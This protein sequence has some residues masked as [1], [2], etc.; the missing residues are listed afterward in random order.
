MVVV[1]GIKSCETAYVTKDAMDTL[2]S[3]LDE[4]IEDMENGR[5]QTLEEAWA[6]IDA[7]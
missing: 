4:A 1:R 7:V 3:K 6:E 5:V 2:L